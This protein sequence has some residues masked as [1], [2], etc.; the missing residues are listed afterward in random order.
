MKSTL[1]FLFF[2]YCGSALYAQ[3]INLDSI[4]EP[5]LRGEIYLPKTGIEG[6]QFYKDEWAKS[7]I[8]LNS[9]EMVFNKQL[10]YSQLE[11]EVIW[12]PAGSF[13][14][15]KLEKHFIDEF[16]FKNMNGQSVRFKRKRVK[17]PT[18]VDSTDIFTEVLIENAASLF[19]FRTVSIENT[20]N[21]L[22]GVLYSVKKI[23]AQPVYILIFP[24]K[25]I[26]S[27]RKISKHALLK[28]TPEKFKA[29]IK[30]I[31]E[32]DHFSIRSEND[33]SRLVNELSH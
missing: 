24:D 19:V 26:I 8:K 1:I 3:A 23:N 31:L 33:L 11:D 17:L 13:R 22:D 10:K 2:I 18:M 27:F 5:K 32:Q 6:K 15:V 21:N 29:T 25:Q 7:D 4:F 12:L 9:G 16:T 20:Y 14:L 28:V 30:N